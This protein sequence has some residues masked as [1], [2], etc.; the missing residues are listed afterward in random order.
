MA[1]LHIFD[2][3]PMVHVG[4]NG[5]KTSYYGYPVGGIQ[6]LLNYLAVAYAEHGSVCMCFDSP[7]FRTKIP[8]GTGYKSGREPN[9]A[10]F[11]QLET[12]YEELQACSIRCEKHR[13]YE[14]D[15]I[16]EWAVNDNYKNF[17]STAIYTND[18]DICH[19][20]RETV[21]LFNLC[22]EGNNI[23]QFSFETG[24]ERGKTIPYNTISAYKVFT[25]CSSD[26]IPA[27]RLASGYSGTQL[28]SMW[29]EVARKV[30]PVSSRRCGTNPDVVRIFAK[31]S[32]IFTPGELEE[33]ENRIKLV[34]P[35]EKPESIQIV[36][37]DWNEIN[38]DALAAMCSRYNATKAL[39]CMKL[40]KL[41]LSEPEKQK[42]KDKGRALNTGE[43]ASDKNLMHT[44]SSVKSTILDLRAFEKEF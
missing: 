2:V 20:V 33:L 14:A 31:H 5:Y 9:P 18:H 26:K 43:Y 38:T 12:L 8:G 34:Y 28:Y 7:S 44:T 16:V 32:G 40:R 11:S 17:A 25:G 15:D 35:A 27:M 21:T 19:S 42:L 13:G 29:L 1:K 6:Y 30:A 10:V 4:H 22:K 37:T 41:P 24:I 36:P 23:D 3:S 39:N